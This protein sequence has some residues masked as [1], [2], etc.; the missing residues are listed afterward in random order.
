MEKWELEK[1]DLWPLHP[2]YNVSR[3]FNLWFEYLKAS[4]TMALAHKLHSTKKGLTPEELRQI[5]DDFDQVIK[6]Y[7]DFTLKD[8]FKYHL[9]FR[10]W[11]E[12]VAQTV[13]GIRLAKPKVV[14]LT[15][16]RAN[17]TVDI[18][19]HMKKLEDYLT[20][21]LDSQHKKG[22][23]HIVLSV[24]MTGDKGELLRQI[25]DLLKI[26]DYPPPKPMIYSRY[27]LEGER[28]HLEPLRVGLRLIWLKAEDP[29]IRKWQLGL[30]AQVSAKYS[31]IDPE[32]DAHPKEQIKAKRTVGNLTDRALGRAVCIM[33]NAARGRFP[34]H[35]PVSTPEINWNELNKYLLKMKRGSLSRDRLE[36]ILFNQ[37][38]HLQKNG[39]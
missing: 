26:D 5:P 18:G 37:M 17:E 32:L 12:R 11:W 38:R 31:Y 3:P 20:G 13:F 23:G 15:G 10:M 8:T 39:L 6:V 25:S 2:D 19:L 27:L 7:N 28:I 33:E 9:P 24:P 30:K 35:E 16:I 34:C 21:D 4:P 14:E 1:S 22:F 36:R 29:D